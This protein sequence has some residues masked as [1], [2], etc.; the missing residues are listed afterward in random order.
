HAPPPSNLYCA[1]NQPTN[2]ALLFFFLQ[3]YAT[4]QHL[5]SFPTRR[6]SDLQDQNRHPP[7]KMGERRHDQRRRLGLRG[8]PFGRKTSRRRWSD[9]KST[10]LNSITVRSRMPS[11]A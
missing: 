5:H 8:K 4:H 10:R 9:R 6:S 3:R 11:S 2:S 7:G 1:A